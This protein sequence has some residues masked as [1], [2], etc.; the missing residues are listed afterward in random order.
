[1]E[2]EVFPKR[3]LS[4]DRLEQ[5][6]NSINQLG[7]A[8]NVILQ[9]PRLPRQYG[10]I[11]PIREHEK[12]IRFGKKE[13]DLEVKV[14]RIIIQPQEGVDLK[15]FLNEL[16]EVC[17]VALPF[18]FFIRTGLFTKQRPTVSDFIRKGIS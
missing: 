17:N 2:I 8:K 18:G 7:M 15:I 5:L 11:M 6:L 3:L 16:R 1:M 13:I 10:N 12:R 4:S 9:G 14:G